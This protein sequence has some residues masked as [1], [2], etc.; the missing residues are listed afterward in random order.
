MEK[1]AGQLWDQ[2]EYVRSFP[3]L[4]NCRVGYARAAWATGHRTITLN[5]VLGAWEH[6]CTV[7]CEVCGEGAAVTDLGGSALSGQH[8]FKAV[9]RDGHL[10]T[11]GDVRF[12]D[13]CR[14]LFGDLGQWLGKPGA[15]GV[16]FLLGVDILDGGLGRV[17]VKGR[18]GILG[19]FDWKTKDISTPH[20]VV[21]AGLTD[22]Y[23]GGIRYAGDL[24][25]LND[26]HTYG[27]PM[28]G[29]CVCFRV[30][31]D[32]IENEWGDWLAEFDHPIPRAALFCILGRT[33]PIPYP[34]KQP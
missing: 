24:I 13:L 31:Q 33:T 4:L 5:T 30:G 28:E 11:H 2:A 23:A 22:E 29:E 1:W 27:P 7:V 10:T 12:L 21:V 15:V 26:Q 20:G 3:E 6:Q 25:R 8:L 17:T 34:R 9:C 32:H 19:Y 16:P 18:D 14:L